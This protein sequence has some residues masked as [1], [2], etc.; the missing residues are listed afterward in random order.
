MTE[1]IEW[2]MLVEVEKAQRVRCDY[3]NCHHSVYRRIHILKYPDGSFQCIGSGCFK[4]LSHEVGVNIFKAA[5]VTYFSGSKALT[6]AQRQQLIDNR[7]ALL[8]KLLAEGL[9]QQQ[10]IAVIRRG[11]LTTDIT[12]KQLEPETANE[13]ES[14]A[15]PKLVIMPKPVNISQAS[16]V[17]NYHLLRK[18]QKFNPLINYASFPQGEK[19]SRALDMVQGKYRQPGRRV[20]TGSV[21][22]QREVQI[23]IDDMV[24]YKAQEQEQE[25][26]Q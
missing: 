4:K 20:D 17:E 25:Q 14:E 2:V 8:E 15:T 5:S 13:V 1:T 9:Q 18:Y 16:P 11:D 26:E 3:P 24:D 12:V 23:L 10:S 21:A 7:S 19:Y 22:F 6:S